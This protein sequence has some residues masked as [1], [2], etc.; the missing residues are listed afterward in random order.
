MS[1]QKQAAYDVSVDVSRIFEAHILRYIAFCLPINDIAC[2]LRPTNK[3]TWEALQECALI[4]LGDPVPPAVFAAHWSDPNAVR[5]LT[6]VQRTRLLS[7][8]AATGDLA[9]L[10][11]A[12]AAA[13]LVP[14][15]DSVSA[16][17]A[18]GELEACTWLLE[19]GLGSRAWEL[20]RALSA[21]ARA[22]QRPAC[23][24]LLG[25][26]ASLAEPPGWGAEDAVTSAARGAHLDMVGWLLDQGAAPSE[27]TYGVVLV[28]AA[29]GERP[30]L[31]ERLL[32]KMPEGAVW[33]AILA[34]AEAGLPELMHRLYEQQFPERRVPPPDDLARLLRTVATGCDLATLQ[35]W[36]HRLRG[37]RE[38]SHEAKAAVIRAAAAA[39]T[40]DWR[41]KVTWLAEQGLPTASVGLE[42]AGCP[43][44]VER[45]TWLQQELGYCPQVDCLAFAVGGGNEGTV[46]FL[47]SQ[48]LQ[49]TF[50]EENTS[51][52]LGPALVN[53]TFTCRE[54]L[55]EGPPRRT[56]ELLRLVREAGRLP[57]LPCLG[58]V[59]ELAL[60]GG[61]LEAAS[62]L[63]EECTAR[64]PGFRLSASHLAW[65]A[66]SGSVRVMEWLR[67]RGCPL[68]PEAWDMQ[69]DE[70]ERRPDE[71][72]YP[73]QVGAAD[74]GCQAALEWLAE[75]GCEMP[76]YGEPYVT[77]A[78]NG[79][80]RTLAV[81]R[82]LRVPLGTNSGALQLVMCYGAPLPAVRQ[83][84]GMLAE[85]AIPVPWA[86]A[87]K[88]MEGV[89]E[90]QRWGAW[91]ERRRGAED[92]DG[93]DNRNERM[94]GEEWFEEL[95]AWIE[96]QR[97]AADKE[98]RE[99]RWGREGGRSGSGR[100]RKTRS[101][102][103]W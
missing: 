96:A 92:D 79:D 13:G 26:G 52:L 47:L 97:A 51:R 87:K 25:H 81:L 8:T 11:V 88:T 10:E 48:D 23:E 77:A 31:L 67:E 75:A 57:A 21:A 32:S 37:S 89:L 29:K 83:L 86:E 46:R 91:C 36:W 2:A 74:S 18:A 54:R 76:T 14:T 70:G 27:H 68:G 40:P 65:G 84:A 99:R 58:Q 15:A 60:Y 39:H 102:E 24:W 64:N 16:A 93:W 100:G 19:R 69:A 28:A 9:N 33:G 56:L 73:P 17:A 90:Y 50:D 20:D 53:V 62:W 85:E 3:A 44:A 55:Y 94:R 41:A 103:C 61:H 38:P 72:A 66:R 95:L 4:F 71:D 78:V 82:R 43:D 42:A 49:G 63:L 7:L 45:L 6:R 80:L 35:H 30:D 34:A 1:E 22:N 5:G 98:S 59:F 12:V 101:R